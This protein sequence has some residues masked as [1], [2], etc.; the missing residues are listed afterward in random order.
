VG[1]TTLLWLTYLIFYVLVLRAFWPEPVV[2]WA[3]LAA[4]AASFSLAVPSSPGAIGV[5][6]AAVAFVMT[7][8]LTAD[9]AAAYA[10]VLHASEI[11]S[12]LIFGAYSLTATGTS[13]GRITGQA[14]SQPDAG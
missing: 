1:C 14:A 4:S 6:H 5:F 13:I 11:V 3:A 10:I 2:A 7:P 12:I 9:T 8:Y